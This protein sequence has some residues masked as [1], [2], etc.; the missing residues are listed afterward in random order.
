MRMLPVTIRWPTRRFIRFVTTVIAYFDI[1]WHAALS[2]VSG[3]LLLS[4]LFCL[5]SKFLP[6]TFMPVLVGICI[7]VRL[8]I[9]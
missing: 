7:M 1:D 3:S 4:G 8:L 9:R 5:F 6:C 2:C